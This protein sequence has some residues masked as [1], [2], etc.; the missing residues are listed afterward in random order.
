M[1]VEVPDFERCATNTYRQR[2]DATLIYSDA[3]HRYEF[4]REELSSLLTLCGLEIEEHEY[5][6]GV[7]RYWCS[8]SQSEPE[9]VLGLR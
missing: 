5:R 4:D 7:L 8:V 9:L 3:D 6:N 2:I 1:Y